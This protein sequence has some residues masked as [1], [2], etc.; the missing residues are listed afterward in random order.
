MLK[1]E[2]PTILDQSSTRAEKIR[3]K[4]S[5]HRLGGNPAGISGMTDE[6]LADH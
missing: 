3:R 6:K 5:R 2:E 4:S 1:D